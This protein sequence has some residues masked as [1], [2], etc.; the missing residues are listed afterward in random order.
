M[1]Y[2]QQGHTEIPRRVHISDKSASWLRR[3]RSFERIGIHDAGSRELFDM[4]VAID[5]A[6]QNQLAARVA[7]AASGDGTLAKKSGTR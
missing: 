2:S 5:T 1:K 6:G 7:E 4:G 3:T